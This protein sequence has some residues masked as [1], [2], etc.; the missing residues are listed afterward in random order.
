MQIPGS[1]PPLENNVVFI[2]GLSGRHTALGTWIACTGV[3]TLGFLPM[4]QLTQVV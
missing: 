2:H 4:V 1:L 3:L